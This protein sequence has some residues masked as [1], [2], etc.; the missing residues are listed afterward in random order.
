ME[1]DP[2][3]LTRLRTVPLAE[4][5]SKVR[6]D[7]F[8]QSTSAGLSL[9]EWLQTLPRLLAGEELRALVDALV[10]AW[11]AR[12]PVIMALGA[13]VVK[14]GL[15]PVLLSLIDLGVV[16]GFA[17]NGATI[18]HDVE[19]ALAGRTSEDV[20]RAL[21]EGTFGMAEETQRFA[22]AA[23]RDGVAAGWGL[24]ESVGQALLAAD[25][26]HAEVSLFAG[27]AARGVPVTVHVAIGT[28]VL[29][30]HPSAD[31]AAIGE[32][33][34]RDF[35][36][37]T[38]AMA[39]LG[40]GGV[41]LNVGSA[42]ILPEVILKS[43]GILRNLGCDLS[44]FVSADLD[45]VRN[46][47]GSRQVVERVS[48]LGGC[49]LALTGHHEILLPLIAALVAERV[50]SDGRAQHGG[51]GGDT[52]RIRRSD[53][54]TG[55]RGDGENE[56]RAPK[57]LQRKDVA[58]VMARHRAAGQ[59][60]VFTNGCFDLLH[61]GHAR[62][63]QQA[64]A[65]GDRLVVGVNSDASVR[66]LKGHGRPWM[67]EAERAEL[68]AALAC[69]DHVALFEEDTPEALIAEVQPHVHVKGGDYRVDDLPEAR[70]VRDMGGEVV[71]VPFTPERSTTGLVEAIRDGQAGSNGRAE[72]TRRPEDTETRRKTAKAS[73]R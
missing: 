57:L 73:G 11:A 29:H 8:A 2:L 58:A 68:L 20:A 48:E 26:P 24:G 34:L 50:A 59:R 7:Q 6:L 9:S 4:R 55:G 28:D 32:G 37:L 66:R 25:A 49:G 18:V 3:D 30:M 13:H 39:G 14:C 47:R 38:A 27:A 35:R 1:D 70:L 61:V 53:G 56:R 21:R 46:Y 64:R 43:L 16:T 15:T 22:N 33:S 19:I 44:G 31:G 71:I 36:I 42:V 17:T 41:L 69:V 67:P 51:H 62:Y 12:K 23:I 60:I 5:V 72:G 54:A 45:F 65:L 10:A 52:E 40:G 63:L